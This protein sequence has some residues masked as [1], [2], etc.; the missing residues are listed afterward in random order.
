ME[1]NPSGKLGR[2]NGAE[3]RPLPASPPLPGSN[4][5]G[6]VPQFLKRDALPFR[7]TVR[8]PTANSHVAST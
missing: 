3:I 6:D 7:R 4:A 2:G 5:Y 1:S 8:R